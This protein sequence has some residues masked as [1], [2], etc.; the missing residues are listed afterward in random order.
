MVPNDR[1][2]LYF[3]YAPHSLLGSREGVND[4]TLLYRRRAPKPLYSY[5]WS[6]ITNSSTVQIL[7]AN[8]TVIPDDFSEKTLSYGN[9][10]NDKKAGWS[11]TPNDSSAMTKAYF[12]R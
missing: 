6:P 4:I 9:V 1:K 10:H 2:L 12:E 7:R 5:G 11:Q 3:H 8:V